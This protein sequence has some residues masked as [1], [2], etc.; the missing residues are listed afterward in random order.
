M[1][2]VPAAAAADVDSLFRIVLGLN[3]HYK[4]RTRTAGRF[5]RRCVVFW[6]M[7]RDRWGPIQHHDGTA[8]SRLPHQDQ[9]GTMRGKGDI[10]QRR[11]RCES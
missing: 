10:L 8:S 6:M 2:Q 11:K 7:L 5:R 4:R 1:Y 3:V 9:D